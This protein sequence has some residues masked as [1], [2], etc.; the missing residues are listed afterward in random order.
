MNEI[1]IFLHGFFF[2]EVQQVPDTGK[3]TLVIASP[4]HDPMMHKFGYWN[5]HDMSWQPF[6]APGSTFPWIAALQDRGKQNF[7]KDILQF[8]RN[9]LGLTTNFIDKPPAR[10]GVYIDL[11][12]LPSKITSLR[13]GGDLVELPM[14]DCNVKKSISSHCGAQLKLVTCLT[15]QISNPVGFND[16]NL[17]A[18][19]CKSPEIG[20]I[21]TLF[22]ETR[23]VQPAFDLKLASRQL[24]GPSSKNENTLCELGNTL[25]DNPCSAVDCSG[26]MRIMMLRTANCPQFGI[27]QS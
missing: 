16:I 19:H 1:R 20:E 17:Y 7:P 3:N 26:P 4:K 14:Q 2:V 5:D 9:D 8:S 6:P 13:D 24:P 12:V 18:S 21:N 15:Y 11:G 22:D 25:K 27:T 23:L 10:Y